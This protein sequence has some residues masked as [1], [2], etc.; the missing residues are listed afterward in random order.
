[1]VRSLSRLLKPKSI[2][3]IGGKEAIAVVKQCMAL[4]YSGDIWPVHP[5]RREICGFKVYQTIKD[6]PGSPDAA[7]IAVNRQQTISVVKELKRSQAGGAICYAS[8]FSEVYEEGSGL[9]QSLI[10]AAGDMP[11]IG[12]NCYG[13]LNC[14]DGIALWPDQH[15]CRRLLPDQKGVAIITQSSNIAINMTMQKRGLPISFVL[16]AGNQAQTGLSEMALTVLDDPRVTVLGLH[17]EGFDSVSGLEAVARKAKSL[18]KPVIAMKIGRSHKARQAAFTHT[19]SLAGSDDVAD[20]F[21]RRIGMARLRTIPSFLEALKLLYIAGPI[22]GHSL[23]S[24]SCSGGEASLMA[25]ACMGRKVSFPSPPTENKNLIQQALGPLVT[26]ENPL[27]YHTYIWGD[28]YCM[29]K[30]FTGMLSAG[31]D[32]NCLIL[33]FPRDEKCDDADW[34]IAVEALEAASKK[35]DAKSAIVATLQENITEDQA[36]SLI[37][38]GITPL[39]GI[40]EAFDAIEAAAAI[41]LSWKK[42]DA[43]PLH[44]H[45]PLKHQI[46]FIPHEAEA[47][48]I[49]STFGIAVPEGKGLSDPGLAAAISEQIGFPV[50]IK[51]QGIAHKTER[52]AVRL[53]I[54]NKSDALQAAIELKKISRDLYVEKMVEH[55]VF[56]LLIGVTRDDQFGLV[57]TVASGGLMVE[58]FQDSQT[59][60]IPATETDFR[61]ALKELKSWVFFE[62]FR[63]GVKAD[64]PAVIATMDA[65][66]KYVIASSDQL[67]ELEINPLIV[68]AEGHGAIAVDAL[69][70]F[71]RE[72]HE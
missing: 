19:A 23:S 31:F 14:A 12:P 46:D 8:G 67:L 6:L 68:C 5:N 4:G 45:T 17:I 52:K 20:A 1:M 41:G 58:V 26:V 59:L 27:D 21:L 18:Q 40:E 7:Y 33:D 53:N 10:E 70:K 30:A 39:C 62:G 66:Q 61:R 9:Q 65:L 11:V 42:P 3:T 13:L 2:A 44:S 48:A 71:G 28:K 22:N 55:P 47:K 51:A 60:L 64:L 57:M 15:G 34:W 69:I 63:G 72:N 37:A 54:C 56:E 49:L 16:T 43:E 35:A 32:F 24:I 38:R 50:A 29:E 36:S 25:D